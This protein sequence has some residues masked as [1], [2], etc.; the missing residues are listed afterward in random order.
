MSDLFYTLRPDKE[1]ICEGV[2]LF[3]ASVE[4]TPVLKL[5]MPILEEAPLRHMNTPGGHR[6]A[7]ST[8]SCGDFGWISSAKGYGYSTKDPTTHKAWPQIPE[9]FFKIAQDAAS[10]AGFQNFQPNSC[11]IN[12]YEPG[13]KLSPHRDEDESAGKRPRHAE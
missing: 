3:P 2:T 11:L 8:S 1:Y 10:K 7:V 13:T 12:R 4:S 9:Y 5:L 6:M